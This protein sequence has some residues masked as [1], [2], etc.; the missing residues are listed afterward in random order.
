MF[1]WRKEIVR[2]T[3]TKIGDSRIALNIFCALYVMKGFH[4]K[5]TFKTPA[6]YTL[7]VLLI[8][9][10]IVDRLIKVP[11]V[12]SHDWRQGRVSGIYT[13]VCIWFKSTDIIVLILNTCLYVSLFFGY[14]VSMCNWIVKPHTFHK[15]I[16]S[17]KN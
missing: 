3:R 7:V 14:N 8:N 2:I 15:M 4:K 16:D 17:N 9:V 13:G 1:I 11:V 6:G 12:D 5:A 10:K